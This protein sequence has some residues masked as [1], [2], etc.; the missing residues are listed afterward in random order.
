MNV[1]ELREKTVDELNQV[2]ISLRED[3]FKLTMQQTTG[4]LG[5]TH[6]LAVNRHDIARVKTILTQKAGTK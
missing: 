4:Q 3:Q 6:L 1:A 5:Q 2:L